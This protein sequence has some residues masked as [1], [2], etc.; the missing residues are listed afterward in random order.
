MIKREEG[1]K[2][3]GVENE[4]NLHAKGWNAK[5]LALRFYRSERAI[6]ALGDYS[7]SVGPRKLDFSFSPPRVGRAQSDV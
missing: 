4:S 1:R 5:S 7:I 3:G 2:G 6:Q